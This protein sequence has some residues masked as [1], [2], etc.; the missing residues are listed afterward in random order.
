MLL[1]A[2]FPPMYT[3]GEPGAQ[4]VANTGVQGWGTIVTTPAITFIVAGFAGLLHM[5]NGVTTISVMV[6]AGW[7]HA[8][9][10]LAGG[11]VSVPG[12]LPNM[13]LHDAVF[14]TWFAINRSL[15]F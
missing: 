7:P 11:T 3:V 4:G 1:K 14:A 10:R 2:G 8:M 15:V 12:A 5:P 13:H 6:A 9:H